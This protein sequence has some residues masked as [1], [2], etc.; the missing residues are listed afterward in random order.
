ML[1]EALPMIARTDYSQWRDMIPE[2]P[3]TYPEW[4]LHHAYALAKRP[5][6]AE[7]AVTPAEFYRYRQRHR[8]DGDTTQNVALLARCIT[9]KTFL[10]ALPPSEARSSINDWLP[11]NPPQAH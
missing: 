8:S 6:A 2:L 5:D 1:A 3:A 4:L 11:P 10:S 9:H 7:I